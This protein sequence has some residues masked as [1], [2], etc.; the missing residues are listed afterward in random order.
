MSVIG[1]IDDERTQITL[2]LIG[3]HGITPAE[4]ARRMGIT[5]S[6]V[7]KMIAGSRST[8][9]SFVRYVPKA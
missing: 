6:A 8:K 7:S 9:V 1:D 2:E 5:I 4:V 3:K